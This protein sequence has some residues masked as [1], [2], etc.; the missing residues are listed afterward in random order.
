MS[1]EHRFESA[2]AETETPS[3]P[4]DATAVTENP[5]SRKYLTLPEYALSILDTGANGLKG[6]LGVWGGMVT[7][8]FLKLSPQG[9]VRLANINALL[10]VV[11]Q[12]Y[13]FVPAR[14]SDRV[15]NHKRTVYLLLIPTAVLGVLGALPIA[16]MYPGISDN[17][18]IAFICTIGILGSLIGPYLGNAQTVLGIRLTPSSR[19]RGLLGTINNTVGSAL[20][21]LTGPVMTVVIFLFSGIVP[22]EKGT[23]SANAYYY[24]YGTILFSAISLV[25]TFSYNRVRQVRI[26]APPKGDNE[27][28][29][30]LLSVAKAILKNRPL[31]LKRLSGVIGAWSGVAGSAYSL[32]VTKYY[33]NQGNGVE[34][35]LFGNNYKPDLGM[36]FFMFS[37]TQTIPSVLSLVVTPFLR[38]RFSDKT[39]VL[40]QMTW[41]L[42]GSVVSF[43][44][45][46]GLFFDASMMQKYWI[47]MFCYHWNGWVFGL[48][49]CGQVMDLELLDYSEWQT[50]QRNECTFNYITGF[51][52]WLCTLPIGIVA[53][54][55]LIRTGYRT[56]RPEA[57][58]TAI[59]TKN[60]FLLNT[61]GPLAGQLLSLIPMLFY[62]FSGEKRKKVLY[63]LQMV[64]D[65][66]AQ[67]QAETESVEQSQG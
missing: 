52:H 7:T 54:R 60:L 16:Y 13:N 48:N 8:I 1:D 23:N 35:G 33:F 22:F 47:H 59:V 67:R 51:F 64:R 43:V 65:S 39:L 66:R 42:V 63:D 56:D 46:S 24:F 49:V 50:G 20:G 26:P 62:D 11:L 17:A 32:I 45:L 38:K 58:L 55:L 53:A 14:L 3:S 30:D 40:F 12:A 37:L 27:K 4:E 61:I 34:I 9:F 41:Y 21:S 29:T 44:G 10:S 15:T 19:E 28:P 5:D 31:V 25:F 36:L 57:P 2:Q 18:K 6:A